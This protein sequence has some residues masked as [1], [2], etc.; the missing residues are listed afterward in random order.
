MTASSFRLGELLFTRAL[1]T[2]VAGAAWRQVAE[3][4]RLH[5]APPR[6]PMEQPVIALDGPIEWDRLPAGLAPIVERLQHLDVH[7]ARSALQ[8]LAFECPSPYWGAWSNAPLAVLWRPD[9]GVVG[10]T[11]D[12]LP[13]PLYPVVRW[14]AGRAEPVL[15]GAAV[16]GSQRAVVLLGPSGAG[17]STSARNAASVGATPLSDDAVLLFRQVD[18]DRGSA[19]VWW[20]CGLPGAAGLRPTTG[21]RADARPPRPLAGLCF[22]TAAPFDRLETLPP[23]EAL[24]RLVSSC[25]RE[26]PCA[27]WLPRP[28]RVTVFHALAE[29]AAS[30]P[31]YRLS[32]R[33]GPEF[34]PRLRDTLGLDR[35]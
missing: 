35:P 33:N 10:A 17:K 3:A 7:A 20:V 25:L 16:A 22:L 32:L 31:V 6:E 13:L 19:E 5:G 18:G 1:A 11:A 15:H 14:H 8:Q 34:Y 27:A 30:I 29:L 2:P 12:T 26:V 9:R 4:C 23:A 21:G 24:D 28:L